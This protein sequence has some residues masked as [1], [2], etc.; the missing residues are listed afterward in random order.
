M[1]RTFIVR[2]SWEGL[3]LSLRAG[4]CRYAN[5]FDGMVC[6]HYDTAGRCCQ[7]KKIKAIYHTMNMFNLDVTAKCLIAEG[8]CPVD[9]MDEIQDALNRGTVS[10]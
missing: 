8:W 10:S 7:V 5:E 3:R 2:I 9:E 4:M 6:C 1:R